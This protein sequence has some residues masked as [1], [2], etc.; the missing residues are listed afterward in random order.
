MVQ[1][2]YVCLADKELLNY[3]FFF[4]DNGILEI[5]RVDVWCRSCSSIEWRSRFDGVTTSLEAGLTYVTH[6]LH[7]ASASSSL[8][9]SACLI[10]FY[11]RSSLKEDIVE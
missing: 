9:S 10:E 8:H 5:G 3:T 4:G 2:V 6:L 1:Q 11:N 7:S